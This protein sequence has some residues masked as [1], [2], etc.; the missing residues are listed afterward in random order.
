V[1]RRA[2]MEKKNVVESG[3]TKTNEQDSEKKGLWGVPQR[4]W[5]DKD[6]NKNMMFKPWGGVG[7]R[8]D[9]SDAKNE[10]WSLSSAKN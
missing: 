4:P 7:R 3:Y 9:V 1:D 8:E 10:R 2:P 5:S 6:E